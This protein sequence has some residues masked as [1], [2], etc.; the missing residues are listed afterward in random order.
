MDNEGKILWPD[1]YMILL[2]RLVLAGRRARDI[3]DVK[4]GRALIEDIAE[5]G[6]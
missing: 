4:C 5:A 2:E 6:R 3:F 1:L